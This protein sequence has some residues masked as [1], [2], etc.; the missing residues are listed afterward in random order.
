[1]AY[2]TLTDLTS[3]IEASELIRL[4]ST[5]PAATTSSPEVVAITTE[6]IQS[7]D[8]QID[9]Y[10]LGR[11]SGLRSYSPVPERLTG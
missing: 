9:G 5:D 10:L 4:C 7:A 6:A 1:M 3:W 2:S 11:W 8:A